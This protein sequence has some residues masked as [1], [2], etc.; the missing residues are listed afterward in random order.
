MNWRKKKTK[1]NSSYWP[2]TRL[3]KVETVKSLQLFK[4]IFMGMSSQGEG[5]GNI[6]ERRES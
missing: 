2:E 1:Q 3:F 6:N 5:A 4:G